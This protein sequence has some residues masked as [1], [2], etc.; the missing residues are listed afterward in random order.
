MSRAPS[1]GSIIYTKDLRHPRPFLHSSTDLHMRPLESSNRTKIRYRHRGLMNPEK[2]K[3]KIDRS[4]PGLRLATVDPAGLSHGTGT[5]R[6]KSAR[7][8]DHV[9]LLRYERIYGVDWL[10]LGLVWGDWARDVEG[11]IGKK[12]VHERFDI[13][14]AWM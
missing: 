10:P 4:R 8:P 9:L 7:N 3:N 2:S 5:C 6:D 12:A 11:L 1:L 13:D 14:L